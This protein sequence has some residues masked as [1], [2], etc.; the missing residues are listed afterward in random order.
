MCRK[1]RCDTLH[2]YTNLMRGGRFRFCAAGKAVR[3]GLEATVNGRLT[4][5]GEICPPWLIDENKQ[6]KKK[7]PHRAWIWARLDLDRAAMVEVAAAAR[8]TDP[9]AAKSGLHELATD[10]S[11]RLPPHLEVWWRG[12]GHRRREEG[13]TPAEVEE[14]GRLT[15]G[16]A[17]SRLRCPTPGGAASRPRR[18]G[19]PPRARVALHRIWPGSAR[20]SC[21]PPGFGSPPQDPA[22]LA[23]P[24]PPCH[25]GDEVSAEGG[26]GA[27]QRRGAREGSPAFCCG[28]PAEGRD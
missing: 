17:A 21:H 11:A 19:E 9:A 5:A 23:P 10:G 2:Y 7:N 12:A 1:I 24:R 18:R 25:H 16:G 27:R 26:K 20:S 3:R 4:A 6:K 8:S 13:R 14:E 28:A 22:A 15:P